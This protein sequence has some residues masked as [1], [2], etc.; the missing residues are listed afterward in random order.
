[1][2]VTGQVT[3]TADPQTLCTLPPG[4]CEVTLVASSTGAT[5]TAAGSPAGITLP[6]TTPVWF[7]TFGTQESTTLSVVAENA[8]GGPVVS[9][10]VS[11]YNG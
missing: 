3:A 2:I 5:V 10:I 9:F 4:E 8:T 11:S 1:M 7:R 6:Q